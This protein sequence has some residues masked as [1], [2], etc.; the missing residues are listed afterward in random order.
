MHEVALAIA[1]VG[2]LI[3]AAHLF[4]AAFRKTRI[5]DVLLLVIIGLLLGPL[6][7][8]ATPTNFGTIGPAFTTITFIFILFEAG[9]GIKLST[10]RDTY[11]ETL[12]LSVAS[13]VVTI[14][15]V[16][17]AAYF[18]TDLGII[19]SLILGTV[20]GGFSS[21]IVIPM[22]GQMKILEN[23]RTV[24][25]LESS[26]NDVFV[27][28][29]T[30]SLMEIARVGDLTTFDVGQTL[31]K[32]LAS[33]TLATM[34]GMI[35]AIG[36]SFLLNRVRSL[37]NSIFTTAAFVFVVFGL[38]EWLGYS[39]AIA[40]LAFG[41]T[42]GNVGA[43]NVAWLQN[44]INA[45]AS[46][47]TVTEKAFFAEMVFI[48]KT[49]FFVYMGISLQLADWRLMLVGL[50]LT[51]IIYIV[52]LPVVKFSLQKTTP[53]MDAS[54]IAILIPRGLAAA[55]IASI[56][57]QQGISGGEIIQNTAYAIILASILMTSLLVILIDKTKFCKFYFWVFSNLGRKSGQSE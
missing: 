56:P 26:L 30:L 5:P 11:K 14:V 2:I 33:F 21:A 6:L 4:E 48:L 32:I 18:L 55:V 28:I 52:R 43:L 24:L 49:L 31:G 36:W 8:I 46:E 9:I 37:Q 54:I 15:A 42:L 39:G 16:G 1:L 27:V 38:T 17:T 41:I 34:I 44:R 7:G 29:G 25:L 57:F 3:F 13:F 22:L 35:S 50:A 40:S 53:L 23:S 45:N 10:L 47:L 12:V 20:V 19:R 51:V